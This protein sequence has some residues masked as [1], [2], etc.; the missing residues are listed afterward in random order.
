MTNTDPA[1]A[2]AFPG[3]EPASFAA[4]VAQVPEPDELLVRAIAAG[5]EAAF[6]TIYDR[7]AGLVYSTCLRILADPQLAQD[8]TQEIFVRLWRRPEAFVPERG[9]F[10]SW[11]MSVARNRAVDDLR[12]RGRRQH[13]ESPGDEDTLVALPDRAAVDPLHAAQVAE[14][15]RRVR[16]ALAE[17]PPGQRTALELAYFGGL[18]QQEIAA[19]LGEPLGTIK[20]RIR[21][22]M[23]KL[24]QSLAEPGT[25]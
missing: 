7:Y 5:D 13:R 22:A 12:A 24:R 1:V 3:I 17:L 6:S 9:R 15:Q 20:T 8:A 4:R 14:Q 25:A 2:C 23:Q 10:L 21:L 11:L 16:A 18:T 19:R